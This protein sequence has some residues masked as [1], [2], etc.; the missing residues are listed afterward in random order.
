VQEITTALMNEADEGMN[1]VVFNAEGFLIINH[2]MKILQNTQYHQKLCQSFSIHDSA[3]ELTNSLLGISD[4]ASRAIFFGL[5][6]SL[7]LV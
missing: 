1:L 5:V 2:Q 4:R 3:S 6:R 7:P